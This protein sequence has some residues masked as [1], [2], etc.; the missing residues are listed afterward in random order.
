MP[1]V[2]SYQKQ[3]IYF[4]ALLSALRR[5]SISDSFATR[6]SRPTLT[7]GIAP[8]WSRSYTVLTFTRSVCATSVALNASGKS[9]NCFAYS[10]LV[11]QYPP[12]FLIVARKLGGL[13][14][15]KLLI[16]K[17]EFAM[18][19]LHFPDALISQMLVLLVTHIH[20]LCQQMTDHIAF[21]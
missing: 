12:L 3:Q 16:H 9:R 1:S 6:Y 10:F 18:T 7:D 19:L 4:A 8:L 17:I 11:I 2:K 13:R 20:I 5:Y 15:V 21:D 14:I